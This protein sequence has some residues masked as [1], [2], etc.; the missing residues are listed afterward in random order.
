MESIWQQIKRTY[1]KVK[2]RLTSDLC[3]L[4]WPW[5][6]LVQCYVGSLKV[7][8]KCSRNTTLL[9]SSQSKE[10]HDLFDPITQFLNHFWSQFLFIISH[11][12]LLCRVK[13]ADIKYLPYFPLTNS[14]SLG[15]YILMRSSG[16]ESSH[17]NAAIANLRYGSNCHL[18]LPL[19][20]RCGSFKFNL[21][22]VP[23]EGFSHRLSF[24]S[25]PRTT[26]VYSEH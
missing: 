6:L 13:K 1:G 3:R 26:V 11:S 23:S 24:L 7:T 21:F 10:E 17:E 14:N 2:L 15:F 4:L 20:L 12:S 16:F 8:A 9:F 25:T 5:L 19:R 18:T 22:K